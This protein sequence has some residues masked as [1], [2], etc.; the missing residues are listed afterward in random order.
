[1]EGTENIQTSDMI[2][3][4]IIGVM[5]DV[6]AV[7]KDKVNKQQGFKFRGI[8]DV[9][10]ALYPAMIKNGVFCTPEILEQKRE[11]RISKNGTNMIYSICRIR[12]TFF[13]KDGSSVQAVVIGEGMDT[14]DKA[15]NKA[16]AIAFKY[17]CF[18]TFCI[19]T[20]EMQ[21]PDAECPDPSVKNPKSSDKNKSDKNKYE[22][23][24]GIKAPDKSE[25][26]MQAEG[27]QKVN[28]AMLATIRKEM[29]R[30]GVVESTLFAL[31]HIKNLEDMTVND[32][33]SV[34]KKFKATKSRE[35]YRNE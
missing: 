12:Y 19:P 26:D 4:A 31:C 34:M 8:D 16:M 29:E 33:M 15:T 10:N 2:Y 22:S 21:D 13:A 7:S 27:E 5:N 30:T 11:E 20:E 32:Y 28:S 18:Q 9:M 24:S 25:E 6:G 3:Q 17:A 1:M 23:S 35:D 14:A